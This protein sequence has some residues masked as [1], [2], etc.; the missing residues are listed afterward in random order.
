[1]PLCFRCWFP[2]L[3]LAVFLATTAAAVDLVTPW[4]RDP[5]ATPRYPETMAWCDALADAHPAVG[6]TAFGAS[7]RGRD[8]PLLVWDPEALHSP[9]AVHAAGRT[10]LLIQACIHAGESCGK[11]A[12]MTLLRDLAVDGGPAGV[13]VLFIPIFN[14]DGHERF[15]PY[16][17]ANQ[18]GPREM[19]WRVT[20]QNL[21]LNRDFAKADAPE[22]QAWLGLWNRWRPHFLVDIH[23]TD[24]A[25]YQYVITH[26]LELHGNLEA[27][28]TGWLEDY[29]GDMETRM[30]AD[31]WPMAPY[32][33]FRRWHD[34]RS[35]LRTWVAGPRFSQGYAAVRNRPGL[36]VEAHMLKPYPQRVRATR[37]LLDH[38]LAHL[39]AHGDSLRALARAAD[40][41]TASAGFRAEPLPVRWEDGEHVRPFTFL[42]VEYEQVTSPLSGGDYFRYHADRPDTFVVDLL[43]RPAVAATAAV[44]EAYLVPPEWTEVI[45]RLEWHGLALSRLVEPAEIEV[46]SWRFRDC[47]W[48]ERP[49]EGRHP[50]SYTA[51]PLTETRRFPAGTVVVDLA[52]PGARIAVHLLDPAGP[53]ALVRWGFFD[54]VLTRVEYIESYAIEALMARMV[55]D[56]PALADSLAARKAADPEFAADPWAIRQWFY[57]RTPY[58]DARAHVYPVGALTDPGF[59]DRLSLGPQF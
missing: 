25:D 40:A 34:P 3:V 29:L 9:D 46:A 44:P 26:G 30:A 57:A 59:R 23:S 5:E 8:L 54:A 58:Y 27:G 36:L 11:D 4:E 35:G 24:G 49:Y 21:N 7:P 47:S 18:N 45:A 22:M 50:V 56:D 55:A 43:D 48:R 39:A 42:G 52:Q 51:A 15:G 28:L 33:T 1:M 31:G 12:G 16:N 6:M 10:V 38:T 17:R 2:T 13:T 32:V 20:A 19:G 53:D 41:F 37:R 14:V